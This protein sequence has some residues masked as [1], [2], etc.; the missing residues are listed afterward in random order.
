MLQVVLT[1]ISLAV[2][3]MFVTLN[4]FLKHITPVFPLP[5]KGKSKACLS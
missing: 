4:M 1:V 5:V 3:L 2:F